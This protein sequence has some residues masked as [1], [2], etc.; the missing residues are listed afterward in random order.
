MSGDGSDVFVIYADFYRGSRTLSVAQASIANCAIE[1]TQE[2]IF[3]LDGDATNP[4]NI[5]MFGLA[6]V[7]EDNRGVNFGKQVYYQ[8]LDMHARPDVCAYSR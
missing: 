3:G 7:W 8:V 5:Q 2:A 4:T 6:F 1:R